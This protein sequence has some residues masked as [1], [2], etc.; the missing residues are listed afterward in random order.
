[1]TLRQPFINR[2]G[3]KNSAIEG[4]AESLRK[5]SENSII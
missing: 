5:L 4:E 2:G 3:A 1:M